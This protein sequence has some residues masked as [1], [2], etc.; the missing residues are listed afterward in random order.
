VS[1]SVS[2]ANSLVGS[3]ANDNVS[4]GGALALTNGNYVVLSPA[5]DNGATS[6]VGAATWGSGATGVNGAVSA[7]NSLV[8][9]TVND[10]VGNGVAALT[11]ANYV[12]L[13]RFWDNGAAIDAGAATWGSGATGVSGPVSASNSLVGSTTNDNIGAAA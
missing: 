5:W 8:G 4:S 13:S 2:A 12:I 7:A 11:N 6:N 1:G 10:N 3:T 9:S